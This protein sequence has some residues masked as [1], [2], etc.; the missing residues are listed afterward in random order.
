VCFAIV[1]DRILSAVDHK[2]KS[3]TALARLSDIERT[4]R[5]TLLADHYDDGDWSAL[6]WVRLAGRAAVH[7]ADDPQARDTVLRLGEKYPQHREYP[8]SGPTC[9]IT[10][11]T[12][13]WWRATP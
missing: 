13:T 2:P 3:T 4:G 11:E 12:L 7:P 1:D 5:A 9:S 6:W 8:P 10:I